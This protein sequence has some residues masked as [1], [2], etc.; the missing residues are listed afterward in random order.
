MAKTKLHQLLELGQSVWM[1]YIRRRLIT[2]GELQAYI[3]KGLRGMTSNP[4]IFKQAITAGDAYDDDLKKLVAEGKEIKEIYEAVAIKDI[5]M[6]ADVIRPVY[7]ETH[8][9]DGYISLEVDPRL[10][11]D[12][13][14]TILEARSL[15]ERVNRPNVYIKIPATHEGIPAIET[16]VSEGFNINITLMFSLGQYDDVAEAYISGLEKLAR[17]RGDLSKVTSVASFFVSRMDV[18]VDEKLEDLDSPEA[19][20]LKGK[21]GI[22]NAKMAY[23]RFKETFKGDRWQKLEVQGAHLQR[24]LW[25]STSTKNPNYPDTLYADNLIGPHT[26]N[27]LPPDTID[28]FLDHGTV[29]PTLERDLD[30]AQAQ[31]QQLAE[32]GIDLEQVTDDLLVEAVE[33]FVSPF[34]D[35]LEAIEEKCARIAA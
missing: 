29:A 15:A 33:K 30:E 7:E 10:A 12:T 31:L 4:S 6:A 23:Q 28:A 18:M 24:V 13:E 32:L 22:A 17:E 16:M 3:D 14:G 2:S 21:I 5:Q 11:H 8:R 35:L 9:E 20:E 1:D 26:V 25:A 19:D 34:D 27:T